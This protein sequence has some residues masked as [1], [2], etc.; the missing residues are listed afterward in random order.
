MH[1]IGKVGIPSEILLKRG[2]LTDVEFSLMK[3][4]TEIGAEILSGSTSKVIQMSERIARYHHE[5]YHFG[6][7]CLEK[8][9]ALSRQ[10]QY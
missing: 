5:R 4:H 6:Y 10:T 2:K 1:D 8:E 9:T 7:P 3:T